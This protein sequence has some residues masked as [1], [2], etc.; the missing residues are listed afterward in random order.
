MSN[1]LS[2]KEQEILERQRKLAARFK[3]PPPSA[4]PPSSGSQILAAKAKP[5][6]SA[7]A[8]TNS[9]TIDLT[10][11]S[12]TT[13][14]KR[15]SKKRPLSTS[16]SSAQAVLAAARV[17][18][19]ATSA[20][21][22]SSLTGRSLQETESKPSP[23][24][25]RKVVERRDSAGTSLAKLVQ[26]V[27]ATSTHHHLLDLDDNH[28]NST[29]PSIEPDDFWKHLREWDFVS[30]L[31]SETRMQG[32]N[33]AL[34]SNDHDLN[35]K[36]PLPNVFLN[37]RHYMS[38]WAPLCLAECRAQV[39]QQFNTNSSVK[40]KPI[41]VTTESTSSRSRAKNFQKNA[42]M[43]DIPW[44]EENETGSYVLIR[45]QKRQDGSDLK[46]SAN[47]LVLLIRSDYP[48]ILNDIETGVARPPDG[49][50]PDDPHAFKSV[51]L[52]GHTEMSRNELNGLVVKVSKRRWAVVGKKEMYLV[53]LGNNITALREFTALC[54]VDQL[55]LKQYL[56]GLHL[57]KVENRRK[58]SSRQSTEQLLQIMGGK[59]SLGPGFIDFCKNKFNASQL[60]AI[61]ASAHEYGDGGFTLIKGPP[62][63][64]KTTTLVTVLNSLHI[65]QYNKYYE[66]VRRIAALTTGSR[67][68]ALEIARKAKPRLLICAPSNAA[69]DNVILKIMAD[70]FIDGQGHRYN[71]SMIRVGV[72]QSD[73]VRA[74]SLE[75]KVDA[76]LGEYSDISSLEQSI[77]GFKVELTR[78]TQ[79]I[80]SLRRRLHAIQHC[81]PYS[82]SKDWEIRIDE[83]SFEDTGRVYYVNHKLKLTTYDLPPPPDPS[84]QVFPSRSMPEYRS[85]LSRIVK[86]VENYFS[87]KSELERCTIISGAVANGANH[88][89][90]RQNMET[91]VLNS[92]HMVMTT[93]GTAGNRTLEGIDKFEVVV[94]D[95]AAQ[96]VEPASLSALQLGNRHCVLVG[97]PQQLPA[98]IFNVSGR[99]SKYDRSLF[100]RLEEAGQPVYMLNEQ[101]RM[102]PKISHFP[103][104]IFY[105]GAL[106]DGPNVRQ[107]DYGD[108]LRSILCRS[109]PNFQPFTI[110]DLDSKEER[111]GTSLANS[112]EARLCVYI[113]QQLKTLTR[114]LSTTTR[115]AIITPYAEQMR[116]LRKTFSN[117]LGRN[118]EAFVEVNTVDAF[119]GREAN[120]VIFSAVRASG[121]HGIGFL[122]DV[123]R[124]NVAL[125]RA[126]HFLFVI[127]RCESIVVNPYWRDLVQH[128]RATNAVIQVPLSDNSS[129]GDLTSW[130]LEH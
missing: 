86:L 98:T 7:T 82:L 26:H 17:K 62:G 50:D 18:A 70:G 13:S 60:T 115:V 105:G 35:S 16:A 37:H 94:V 29:M 121:S 74:V 48:T 118:Y 65:R 20:P 89:E 78:I 72:G 99:G 43:A 39:L 104:H 75:A 57:E 126:K 46:F 97:D 66:E 12:D 31:A 4:P 85:Y 91:H 130:K 76:I 100:Q 80:A 114:G 73:A 63:T 36:K 14:Q 10:H 116:L 110:L 54:R 52:V 69:V 27:T 41:L 59:Q 40:A 71:P 15:P 122:S 28:N 124:M 5:H 106:L 38:A 56:F 49:K 45:P 32:N 119:Q 111:G 55:P 1:K 107:G 113:Y 2:S 53:P 61:T 64:G 34:S 90:I 47:D 102:H 9:A 44:M 96:S 128:A 3:P 109:V 30:Q 127:A 123:R 19:Q 120:I 51:G 67:Q 22:K 125:T 33:T 129:F 21:T 95:E 93:L 83:E 103:R 8:Q 117:E 6:P 87:V 112:A 24:L 11:S 81:S 108:P 42:P 25:K 79:D 92:V 23:K 84:E 58:L 77:V 68:A 88:I 101:Y